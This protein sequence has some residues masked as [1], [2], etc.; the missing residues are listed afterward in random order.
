MKLVPKHKA[1]TLLV[2]N[3]A[4]KGLPAEVVH[5]KNSGAWLGVDVDRPELTDE[6]S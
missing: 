1:L 6:Y 3:R 5:E 4:N 2:I